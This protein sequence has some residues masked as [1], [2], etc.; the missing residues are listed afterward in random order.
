MADENVVDT[1]ITITASVWKQKIQ[2]GEI[3]PQNASNYIITPDAGGQDYGIDTTLSDR[4]S[5]MDIY[6]LTSKK[7]NAANGEAGL[8]LSTVYNNPVTSVNITGAGSTNVTSNSNGDI[9]V[10]SSDTNVRQSLNSS[11]YN[12]PLL[13]SYADISSSTSNI[14]N[15]VSRNNSIHANPSTGT[16]TANGYIGNATTQVGYGIDI[17]N[18]SVTTTIGELASVVTVTPAGSGKI[19]A[20]WTPVDGAVNYAFNYRETGASSWNNRTLSSDTL[21]YTITGLRNNVQH[22]ILVQAKIG[23]KWYPGTG[24]YDDYICVVTPVESISP[25]TFKLNNAGVLDIASGSTNG[26]I[27]A[28]IRGTISEIAVTGLG[29]A[30]YTDSTTYATSSHDHHSTSTSQA[31][32]HLGSGSTAASATTCPSGAWY[33]YHD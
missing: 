12:Y 8:K 18:V 23:T 2:S 33:G 24:V 15:T 4:I 25:S 14:D 22:D 30:A 17:S 11:N 16:I 6:N 9:I 10:T 20:T 5:S 19:M 28:N 3:T 32:R 13:M 27:K 21:T 26:T 29:T 7:N 31:I 1:R